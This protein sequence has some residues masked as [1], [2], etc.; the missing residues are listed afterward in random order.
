MRERI[1]IVFIAVAIGLIVTTLIFFLYQQTRTIPKTAS[2][3]GSSGN[4]KANPT[5][6][7]SSYLSVDQPTNESLLDRRLIQVK[8]RTHAG[9]TIIVSTNQEDVVAK[10]TSEGSFSVSITIDAGTNTITT[11][12]IGPDG[13][14]QQDKRTV[15]YST[16]DF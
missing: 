11:R 2:S 9:D 4:E 3:N 15:T 13:E 5:P 10:P 6:Q 7:S 1:L 16:E 8:G 14:E 12:S